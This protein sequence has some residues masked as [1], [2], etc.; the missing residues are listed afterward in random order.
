MIYVGDDEFLRNFHHGW[1]GRPDP[2]MF[3]RM[4][5]HHNRDMNRNINRRRQNP[6]ENEYNQ[7]NEEENVNEEKDENIYF[8]DLLTFPKKLYEK[9]EDIEND[10]TLPSIQDFKKE[11]LN[12]LKEDIF[13]YC[14]PPE[15]LNK[16]GKT[17]ENEN[18][19]KIYQ[20]LNTKN[21]LFSQ[22]IKNIVLNNKDIKL[23]DIIK[24]KKLSNYNKELPKILSNLE[25]IEENKEKREKEIE[26]CSLITNKIDDI[27]FNYKEKKE[28][29]ILLDLKQL[30]QLIK[31]NKVSIKYLGFL[32]YNLLEI[33]LFNLLNS[34]LQ[35]FEE[36]KNKNI[37]KD[38]GNI[39]FSINNNIKS[40]KLLILLIKF[41]ESHNSILDSFNIEQNNLEQLILKDVINFEK[42]FNEKNIK[43]KIKIDYSLFWNKEEIKE[44][45]KNINNT[46]Y[47]D[48]LTFHY[49]DNLFV[50]LNYKT[51]KEKKE[52]NIQNVLYYLK[53]NIV[54][55][56]VLNYGK[57]E[58]I[59]ENDAKEEKI[60]DVNISIKNEFIYI[61]YLT[62]K[63]KEERYLKYKIYNQSKIGLIK[64][65]Q[66]DFKK[67]SCSQLLNDSKYL[68]CICKEEKD[69]KVLVIQKKLKL[70]NQKY[71]K[72]KIYLGKDEYK[73]PFLFKIYNCLSI[74]NIFILELN[75]EKYIANF[76]LN[77]KDE[78]VL[79]ISKLNNNINEIEIKNIKLSFNN[80]IFFLT[81]IDKN[82][83]NINITRKE[84][85]DFIKEGLS[86]L[87]FDSNNYNNISYANNTYEYLLQQY[88]SY[89]NYYGNFDLLSKETEN[90]LVEENFIYCLNFKENILDFFI[91]KIIEKNEKENLDIKLYYIIILKQCICAMYNSGIFEEKKIK[92]LFDYLKAFIKK[93]IEEKNNSKIFNK[94]L[95]EVI[96]IMSYINESTIIE[97]KEMENYLV[98]D[99]N[100]TNFLMLELLLEQ[101]NTQNE[102]NLCKILINFDKK[103]LINS[104][105]KIEKNSNSSQ[106][107]NH[108]SLY[109]KIIS[110]S[111]EIFFI[112]YFNKKDKLHK[113]IQ[114][115]EPL[116]SNMKEI[117]KEYINIQN[118][119]YITNYSLLYLSFNFR[120]FYFIIQNIIAKTIFIEKNIKI[121]I[122]E[123]L[124]ALDSNNFND[125]LK[126]YLDL[127]NIY[128]IK[129]SSL[130]NMKEEQELDLDPINNII[131]KSSYFLGSNINNNDN[132][133]NHEADINKIINVFVIN[134]NNEKY[135]INLTKEENL[136]YKNI[137][138]IIINYIDKSAEFKNEFMFYIIPVKDEYKYIR[139][140]ENKDNEMIH[141]IEKSIILYLLNS[142]DRIQELINNY[143]KDKKTVNN[144]EL[145][146]NEIFKYINIEQKE[147][148]NLLNKSESLK[149]INDIMKDEFNNIILKK[150]LKDENKEKEKEINKLIK[151]IIY[152][153]EIY[154]SQTKKV[155]L[156]RKSIKIVKSLIE[157]IFKLGIK[158]YNY[159][160]KLEKIIEE[161][162][163][164]NIDNK[165]LNIKAIEN[166]E[167]FKEIFSLYKDSFKMSSI[168]DIE[169]NKFIAE[170]YDKAMNDYINNISKKL[171]FIDEVISNKNPKDNIILTKPSIIENI[172]ILL[173]QLQNIETHEI[174]IY[175]QIQNI[176]CY[177]KLEQLRL[178]KDL[179]SKI[180]KEKNLSF[181]L[182]IMNNKIK[183]KG[184]INFD[185]IYGANYSLIENLIKEFHRIIEIIYEKSID[186][187]NKFSNITRYELLES[188][189]WKIRERDFDIVIKI[190]SIF[191]N[192]IYFDKANDK[193]I[194]LDNKCLYN[195]KYFNDENEYQRKK[196]IFEIMISQIFSLIKENILFIKNNNYQ[197]LIEKIL[198]YFSEIRYENPYYHDFIL[199]FYKNIL[200][201]KEMFDLILSSKKNIINKILTISFSDNSNE[202]EDINTHTKLIMIKLLYQILQIYNKEKLQQY[203]FD[204]FKAKDKEIQSD[205]NIF[206]YLFNIILNKL[207]NERNEKKII[208]KYYQSLLII[209]LN[210][211]IIKPNDI[212]NDKYIISLLFSQYMAI[213][214]NRYIIKSSEGKDF[215]NT[216]L[217]N[218]N[219]EIVYNTGK[220]LCFL[221]SQNLFDNYLSDNNNLDFDKNAFKYY[222][223][224]DII[225]NN[226]KF[227]GFVLSDDVLNSEFFKINSIDYVTDVFL[228]EFYENDIKTSFIKNNSE[229]IINIIIKEFPSLNDKG[230]YLS[231]K[232]II[233]IL[234][235]LDNKNITKILE[236]LYNY[237]INNKKKEND[238]KL[239]SLEYIQEKIDIIINTYISNNNDIYL[240]KD[241][242]KDICNLFNFY[243]KDKSLGLSLKSSDNIKWYFDALK[244]LVNIENIKEI[245]KNINASNISFYKYD[246]MKEEIIIKEASLLFINKINDNKE[247]NDIYNLIK[248]KNI[249]AIISKEIYIKEED[250][251]KF[252]NDKKIPIYGVELNSVFDKFIEFFIKGIGGNYININNY[253]TGYENSSGIVNIFKLNELMI[254]QNKDDSDEE[255]NLYKKNKIKKYDELIEDLQKFYCLGNIKLIKRIIFDILCL[256]S[257]KYDEI[258]K[259]LNI[260]EDDILY[261]L[262]VLNFE[263][264]F[265]INNNIPNDKLKA[266]LI[267]YMNKFNEKW[268]N[269][270]FDKYINI[271][272]DNELYYKEYLDLFNINNDNNEK[273]IYNQNFGMYINIVYDKLLFVLKNCINNLYKAEIFM[274]KYFIFIEKILENKIEKMKDINNRYYGYYDDDEEE[275]INKKKN[276][277]DEND[278]FEEIFIL[279]VFKILYDYIINNYTK[280]NAKLLIKCFKEC[281]IDLNM[282]NLIEKKI[283]IEDYFNERRK[284]MIKKKDTLMIQLIFKYF[285]F[286]LILFF[287]EK[288]DLYLKYW[289]KTR[290]QLFLFYCNYKLLSTEKYYNEND[291]KEIFSLIAYISDSIDCFFPKNISN[292]LNENDNTFEM[293]FSEFNKYTKEIKDKKDEDIITSFSNCYGKNQLDYNKLSVFIKDNN[294]INNTEPKYILQEII[295]INELKR[296]KIDYKI[297]LVYNELYL[298]PLNNIK[299]YLYA[300]GYNYNN[301]LGINENFAKFYDE[302]KKCSGI[303]KYSWNFSYGQNY[304]ISLDEEENK[305]YSC[306]SGKG[307]GLSSTSQKEFIKENKM[308]I[309]ENNRI[310]DIATG[311]C[312]SSIILTQKGDIYGIGKNEKNFLRIKDLEGKTTLK[313]PILLNMENKIKVV[314]MSMGYKNCFVINDV[315]ELYGIGDN[316][317]G[318]IFNDLDTKIEKWTKIELPEGCK[319][320]I[321]CANGDRYLICL[322]EDYKGN[323]K[324]YARG[325]NRNHECGIKNREETYI[326]N[327]TQCDETY[328]IN[329]KSI[330]TRNN[331]SAAITTTGQLYIWGQKIIKNYI[332]T[333]KENDD[334]D[335]KSDKKRRNRDD[336]E[337][338]IKCPTLVEFDSNIKNPIIDQVAISNTHLLA[339]GRCLENG[340]YVKKLFSCGNN[341]KGALGLKIRSF[342]DNNMIDK[343]TEVKII[344]KE[345]DNS[346]LIPIKLSIGIHRSFVLCVDENELIQEIKNKE[347]KTQINFNI[348]INNFLE[349]RMEKK[350]KD[351]YKNEI[352]SGKY[353]NNFRALSSQNYIDFVDTIDKLKAD[354]RILTSNIFYN[355][356]LNYLNN[357]GN[358]YDFFM[359]FGIGLNDQ[360]INKNESESIFNYLK[361]RMILVENNIMKYCL[362]NKRSEYKEFLQKIIANNIIYLPNKVRTEKFEELLSNLNHF[363]EDLKTIKIDRFKA[364]AFYAEYNESHQKIK[365][366]E[367]DETIFGQVFHLIKYKDPKEY[368]IEKDSRLFRVALQDEHAVDSGGPYNDVISNIC[369]ELQSDYLDILIKTP[370]NRNNY[371]LLNDKYIIN[372]NS[373]RNIYNE[374][375]EFL[376]KLMA[377]FISTAEVLDLNLHPIIWKSLLNKEITLYDYESLDYYFY[378]MINNL[379]YINKISDKDKKIKELEQYQEIYF[380]IKNSNDID[381]ELKPNGSQI[382]LTIDNLKEYIE[383]SKIKRI[384]EFNNSL[385]Y[386]K[387]GFYSVI[388][389]DILQVLTWPQL[390]EMICGKNKLNIDEFKSHTVLEGFN[391]DDDIIKWFWDWFETT[392]EN[393]RIKYLKFVSGRSRL[394]KSSNKIKYKHIISKA[395]QAEKN[396][397]P[398]SMTCF[399]KLNLPEY[400]SKEIFIEKMKYAI[401]YCYEIDTDQ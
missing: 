10:I 53:I 380:V 106:I 40:V 335:N 138:K 136:I 39:L 159:Q 150:N 336:K 249:K 188:L 174:L 348:K 273:S 366:F 134:K 360:K 254:N 244:I 46:N 298:V 160:N 200:N 278:N 271:N 352:I 344:D 299:T 59:K 282:K 263:F 116:I 12:K 288:E 132:H 176:N 82:G 137:K 384:K 400:D 286:C 369:E 22:K 252:I 147:I 397:F 327:F 361:T 4:H 289:M 42:L 104:F 324:I 293:K 346:N 171:D 316:T 192:I 292:N 66:L 319:K 230:K 334:D 111:C 21:F 20:N 48:Y 240:K 26:N 179:L 9:I 287:R 124:L 210:K 85:N 170:E 232:I 382:K 347:N 101:K 88:S 399:F 301:S 182:N 190:L 86:L 349:E 117:I 108:Y 343:L 2:E 258:K 118:N 97:I 285:D 83:Y 202:K 153:L 368:F 326:N 364:K 13:Y 79:Y 234:N 7:R 196:E 339:I 314:S 341:K 115:I 297:K 6:E 371:D 91:K 154:Y 378:T 395:V 64:E 264:Y 351:F 266:N 223:E 396:G 357:K 144:D 304:C 18:S 76:S 180:N 388:S 227:C 225:E 5:H 387:K 275:D 142:Y 96:Y 58:L 373:N 320:F 17:V 394:P 128:E 233:D 131:I 270:Y 149:E 3:E 231:L 219:K 168:Y 78:Y 193:Q 84:R 114:L 62:E 221:D 238:Y 181:L 329:F 43:N 255:V 236:L 77:E 309:F 71:T 359:I 280:E 353:I 350:L 73:E 56:N 363:R 328:G 291:S 156:E 261:I 148:D 265:N 60:I 251:S 246:D 80:N 34:I 130:I 107:L 367:L 183:Y 214:E 177:I 213:S 308:N 379:E 81:K 65:D 49:Y 241:D 383:L 239:L 274:E 89:L 70:D 169:R 356:F 269:K 377:S 268:L 385:E 220:I 68:Y 211:F 109:K 63:S 133:E 158:Y 201:S 311:N 208:K 332:H 175:S 98:K 290:H 122:Q 92:N 28:E 199:L 340:N 185:S 305:I 121:K 139:Y 167:N 140:K 164:K 391:N 145:Y 342:S 355:E 295:D 294:S 45:I 284:N 245:Y 260:N 281:K 189:L 313:S 312:T 362:I 125:K 135:L 23:K 186:N 152:Y 272:F 215:E 146:Q 386:L 393:E 127:N 141:L 61:F 143:N 401:I 37:I 112:S 330:Y 206:E 103:Y 105:N 194:N 123:M 55:K 38:L 29:E 14:A 15:I 50:F 235:Q 113:L 33:S 358:K 217:F 337:E 306:G 161:I 75:E 370:N 204:F 372:P 11:K 303:S 165:E 120:L 307:A 36:K 129:I 173:K 222:T 90:N 195:I 262:E 354:E 207:N 16:L 228:Q 95:K 155:D 19:Y 365:D 392:N 24:E 99:I 198:N 390:E 277:R 35:K 178:I 331:R 197:I 102:D 325:I 57:I 315:G 218:S 8:E 257:I 300:F 318:Q 259:E 317:R 296:R 216:A 54:E 338:D 224:S 162:N 93:N 203:L 184:R 41:C 212:K 166:I 323:G 243:I 374:A 172:F 72:L 256:D 322:V 52:N 321:Q 345:K 110:K 100:R 229:Q 25:Y 30:E 87:P 250:L 376:G 253:E 47:N 389:Y 74:N 226:N 27:F 302:P 119:K 151:D 163:K 381:I 237:Y 126:E 1:V 398:K 283:D 267:K 375:Y 32:T 247:L 191:E 209:F 67:Y 187:N 242:N 276:K 248:D 205:I 69:Y 279:E 44:K 31:E 157:K 94:I 51:P 333:Y 310:V